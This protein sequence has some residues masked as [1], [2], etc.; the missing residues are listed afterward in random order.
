MVQTIWLSV[1]DQNPKTKD[2]EI[3]VAGSAY[4]PCHAQIASGAFQNLIHHG[5]SRPYCHGYIK[6]CP[7]SRVIAGVT[8]KHH[9]F[10]NMS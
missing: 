9:A 10:E 4:K 7:Q 6:C 2:W 3:Q 8:V 5:C 1:I